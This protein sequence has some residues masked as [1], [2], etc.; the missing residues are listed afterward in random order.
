MGRNCGCVL[1]ERTRSDAKT[2][3]AGS[4]GLHFMRSFKKYAFTVAEMGYQQV[5]SRV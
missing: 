2:H 1:R 5:V 3:E 4:G